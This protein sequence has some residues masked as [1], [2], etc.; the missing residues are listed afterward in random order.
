TN[1]IDV[2]WTNSGMFTFSVLETD[3]NGCVGEEVTLLVNI[4]FNSVEDIN[5][6]TGTLTKITDV[7]GRESKEKSNVPLFYIY[8]DGTVE[9]KIIIE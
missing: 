9:K 5:F 2:K 7:L 1:S 8:N 6:N 3:V 4:I